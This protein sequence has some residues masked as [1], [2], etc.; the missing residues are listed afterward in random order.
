MNIG[1]KIRELRIAKLMTQAELAGTQI[2]RN[3][4]SSIE[5][6][7]AQ[8][9]LSTVLYIAKRLNVPA[10]FLLADEGDE[11][12]YRKMTGFGNIKRAYLAPSG[13]ELALEVTADAVRFTVPKVDLHAMAV[14]EYES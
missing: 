12:I 6:G 13:E 9:S 4:L 8:P 2:T 7:A 3:M 5:N 10:G 14:L 1:E 11:I